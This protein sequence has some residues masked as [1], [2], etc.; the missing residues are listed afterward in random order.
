MI[1]SVVKE[2]GSRAKPA[3]GGSCSIYSHLNWIQR[4]VPERGTCSPHRGCKTRTAWR[5]GGAQNKL[6]SRAA[7]SALFST[8]HKISVFLHHAKHSSS[9]SPVYT[10][11]K[12]VF[13]CI[14]TGCLRSLDLMLLVKSCLLLWE[15]SYD[16]ITAGGGSGEGGGTL[17]CK[18]M[19]SSRDELWDERWEEKLKIWRISLSKS[20][21]NVERENLRVMSVGASV[22]H[23]S[24]L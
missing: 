18:E 5:E 21:N 4:P 7:A 8:H 19:L 3:E 16:F 13:Y 23:I 12:A 10:L 24:Q 6:L 9:S 22:P 14:S 1:L 15:R 11:K 2:N 17:N 20:S